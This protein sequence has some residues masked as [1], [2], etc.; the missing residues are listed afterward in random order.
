MYI[1]C[2]CIQGAGRAVSTRT[3]TR[4]RCQSH[5][6]EDCPRPVLCWDGQPGSCSGHGHRHGPFDASCLCLRL[7][8][9]RSCLDYTSANEER[10]QGSKS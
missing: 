6:Y 10:D 7:L 1:C 8:P 5:P 2:I 3:L 4:S 9:A